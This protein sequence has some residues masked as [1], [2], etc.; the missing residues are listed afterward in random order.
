MMAK[1]LLT[2]LTGALTLAAVQPAAADLAATAST[3][4]SVRSGPGPVYPVIAVIDANGAAKVKGCID[5]TSWCRVDHGGT[6]GWAYADY[7]I[8]DTGGDRLVVSKHRG[9]LDVP[10]IAYEGFI[11]ANAKTVVG[12]LKAP[13]DTV[14]DLSQLAVE[15]PPAAV[16]QIKSNPSVP[17]RLQGEVV[18]GAT[19]PKEIQLHAIPGYEHKYVYINEMPVLVDDQRRIVYVVRD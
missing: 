4:L 6:D 8:A 10:S 17:V 13:L 15:P 16:E 3:D 19:V 11:G 18:I 2:S 7:L 14:G 12:V 9:A 5:E 1:R